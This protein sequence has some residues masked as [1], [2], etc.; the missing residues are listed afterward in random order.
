[1][2]LSSETWLKDKVL[3]S[4]SEEAEFDMLILNY[5][6]YIMSILKSCPIASPFLSIF[7]LLTQSIVFL[8]LEQ[9]SC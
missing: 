9:S 3:L 8:G 6:T 2:L 1:M 4:I 7:L 5:H